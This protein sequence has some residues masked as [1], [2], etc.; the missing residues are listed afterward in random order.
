MLTLALASAGLSQLSNEA[1]A[2]RSLLVS[3]QYV[4][5]GAGDCLTDG[6]KALDSVTFNHALVVNAT[7]EARARARARASVR[8]R[9]AVRHLGTFIERDELCYL[10][11]EEECSAVCSSIGAGCA[12]YRSFLQPAQTFRPNG[13]ALDVR[14]RPVAC[15]LY[16]STHMGKRGIGVHLWKDRNQRRRWCGREREAAAQLRGGVVKMPAN[17]LG[18]F[19]ATRGSTSVFETKGLRPLH[20]QHWHR[21]LKRDPPPC[22][23]TRKSSCCFAKHFQVHA[24][25]SSDDADDD[26]SSE[27][28]WMGEQRY[29][30]YLSMAAWSASYLPFL[31]LPLCLCQLRSRVRR[32]DAIRGSAFED[33]FCACCFPFCT[34]T[35]LA[36]HTADG[37]AE[38][39]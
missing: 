17:K 6:G 22:G 36:H 2:A 19:E 23:R 29:L 16:V 20:R 1:G 11:P 27:P 9:H 26:D 37:M 33:L 4:A 35:Q 25:T 3:R 31:A 5:L 8:S 28:A 10:S 39:L 24:A 14:A 34:L 32:E 18:N 21:A 13:S 12:G 30:L 38:P 15:Q 7:R